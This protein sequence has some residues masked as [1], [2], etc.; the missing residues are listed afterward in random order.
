MKDIQE[1]KRSLA[2]DLR[3]CEGFVGV[4]IHANTI[5]LYTTDE[6]APVVKQL[7]N[8]WGATYQ[9]YTVSVVT[10]QG[11]RIHAGTAS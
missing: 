10:S 2:R 7:R 1:A 3:V 9:G 8:R 4:G 5:R 6:S 11:F